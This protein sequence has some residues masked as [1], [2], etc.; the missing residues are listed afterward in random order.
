MA[1][2]NGER[3]VKCL[4][5]LREGLTPFAEQRFKA[6]FGKDWTRE[7][8]VTLKDSFKLD[9]GG[10]IIWDTQA[11]LKAIGDSWQEVF[12]D[13]FGH[14][15]RAWV[16]ELRTVRNDWAHEKT[17]ST[18]DTYRA[19]DTIQLLLASISAPKQASEVGKY[20]QELLRNKYEEQ[21]R[22]EASKSLSIDGE[23]SAGLK[24][25]REIVTPHP[26]VS[27]GKYIQ[28]E[29]AADLSQVHRQ[30]A[31]IEYQDP[32]EFYRRTY[33]TEGLRSL[34]SN[35]LKRL[36]GQGGDPVIELQT[37][38][39]GGKTHSMLA[40]YHLFSPNTKVPDLLGV[41]NLIK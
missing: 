24:S 5:L 40:L 20:K 11:L 16:S 37:S 3:I 38:F 22:Y 33:L 27:S 34:L 28:A 7:I 12:R 32:K 30:E 18:D 21:A 35:A 26:D 39:G 41:D 1:M 14:N 31:E 15:E 2:N 23:P 6:H 17:F 9:K 29:F 13:T 19:L 4:E 25:W 8:R 36:S 10:N